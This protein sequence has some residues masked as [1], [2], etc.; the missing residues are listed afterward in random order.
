MRTADKH[1]YNDDKYFEEPKEY[2]KLIRKTITERRILEGHIENGAIV[3]VGCANGALLT[4]LGR[5]FE[6]ESLI[7]YEP[8]D[9]LVQ[10]GKELNSK[11]EFVQ[12]GL[13]EIET[14]ASLGDIVMAT[15]VLG[16]FD[17]PEEFVKK[18]VTLAKVTSTILIFSPFNE[19]DVDVL[20]QY[21]NSEDQTYQGGHNLFSQKTMES[22]ASNLDLQYEWIDF[23][24]PE[25]I[26]KT[27]DPMRSWTEEFR[28]DKN[29]LFYG[30]NMFST[31]K[32]LILKRSDG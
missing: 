12:K 3:D 31:M 2:F 28:G 27:N 13:Y 21:K 26:E 23:V 29:H 6:K 14:P 10:L 4:Y 30:T 32:L 5:F 25:P 17:D 20:V 1:I 7:G 15:G 8:V 16:I 11:I 9:E 24:M 22:I 18:L 19:E